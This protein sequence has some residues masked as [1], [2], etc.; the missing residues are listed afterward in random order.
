MV[1]AIVTSLISLSC[2]LYSI[3]T[4]SVNRHKILAVLL[5]DFQV[6]L[7]R[8][9]GLTTVLEDT[10]M[11]LKDTQEKL[12]VTEESLQKTQESLE[13]ISEAFEDTQRRLQDTEEQLK[14]SVENLDNTSDKLRTEHFSEMSSGHN[15][16]LHSKTVF[17]Y[18]KE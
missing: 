15:T 14:V 9:D 18:K 4:I 16:R 17:V 2:V 10:Q 8:L 6:K 12:A 7:N 1:Q 11:E 13:N 3:L 5:S